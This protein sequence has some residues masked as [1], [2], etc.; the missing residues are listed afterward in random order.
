MDVDEHGK[1]I[2]PAGGETPPVVGETPPEGTP[3][4]QEDP[5]DAETP[6]V[7]EEKGGV[8]KRI[9]ELTRGK[10][11]AE[12]D[13]EYWRGRAEALAK[14]VPVKAETET[15]ELNPDDFDDDA[16]YLRAVAKQTKDELREAAE[17]E[18]RAKES[19]VIM[20]KVTT[21][22]ADARKKYSDFDDVALNQSLQVTG[23]M[24]EAAVGDNLGDVLYYLGKNPDE[25]T[26]IASLSPTQQIKEIGKIE[27]R[28]TTTPPN[29]TTNTPDPPT[30]VGGGGGSP[31]VKK[32]E[33]MTRAELHAKWDKE[34][35]ARLGA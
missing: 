3:P 17:K 28:L 25:A 8:Q 33:E 11:S 6:P 22:Y 27:T 18:K 15:E 10:R 4:S 16:D 12:R 30:T 1:P 14:P 21:Q 29:T 23:A 35:R 20:R 2:T 19:E 7:V 26:R 32:E 31:P 24:F 9:D 13:A 5:P 34:R